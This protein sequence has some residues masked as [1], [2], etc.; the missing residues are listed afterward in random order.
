MS[1]SCTGA[2]MRPGRLVPAGGGLGPGLE[3]QGLAGRRRPGRR[4]S[5]PTSAAASQVAVQQRHPVLEQGRA[6][7]ASTAAPAC[8]RTPLRAAR[9]SASP[10]GRCPW[11]ARAAPWT[12]C[13]VYAASGGSGSQVAERLL[14]PCGRRCR[15]AGQQVGV[16][17]HARR[18]RRPGR[19]VPAAAGRRR[20]RHCS[21]IAAMSGRSPRAPAS[22]ASIVQALHL[23]VAEVVGRAPGRAPVQ[24]GPGEVDVG[25][26]GV[27]E[28]GGPAAGVQQCLQR[29]LERRRRPAVGGGRPAGEALVRRPGARRSPRSA[30]RSGA[31]VLAGQARRAFSSSTAAAGSARASRWVIAAV[32]AS[33]GS[34][35]RAS[36][37]TAASARRSGPRSPPSSRATPE[38][39]HQRGDQLRGRRPARRGAGR[40]PAPPAPTTTGRRRPAVAGSV[41]GRCRARSATR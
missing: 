24:L 40:A 13:S 9:I 34:A 38:R 3:Q 12:A 25:A 21:A 14:R 19:R 10:A 31:R 4:A 15:I 35:V 5:P 41:S 23:Q 22:V 16:G 11:S 6:R 1:G 18:A 33:H 32:S 39:A 2:T 29:R 28:L 8:P 36:A 7:R 27:A 17:E 20:P 26:V 37:P 30:S